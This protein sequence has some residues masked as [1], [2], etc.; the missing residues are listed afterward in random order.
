MRKLIFS[1]T[2]LLGLTGLAEAHPGHSD[3]HSA[4][5]TG[6]LHPLSGV[7]HLL[8][9]VVVGVWAA[10]L[11]ERAIWAVPA[12]FLSLLMLGAALAMNGIAPPRV[13]A[14]VAT[15][16]L[17]LGL[18]VVR[19]QR[20]PLGAAIAL[21]SVFALFHGAAHGNELPAL[22]DPVRYAL[23]FVAATA[24]LHAMG[25]AL[26]FAVQCRPALARAGGVAT[27]LVGAG[28]LLT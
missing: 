11:G 16:L 20:L 24:L 14:G 3:T 22:A 7:D 19:T 18:L 10:Q 12:A 8:G 2:L 13:E 27:A 6:L 15:S 1:C 21:T 26:G 4:F 17:L 23:G 5:F 9:M 28:L 25:V